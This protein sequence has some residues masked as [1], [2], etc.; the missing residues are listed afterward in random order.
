MVN[1]PQNQ[2]KKNIGVKMIATVL[3]QDNY[4]IENR[5]A[6]IFTPI[7]IIFLL[8]LVELNPFL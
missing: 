7:F 4:S 8:L 6:N 3:L 1:S 2:H 5:G